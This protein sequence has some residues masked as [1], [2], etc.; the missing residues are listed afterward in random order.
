M[1][2]RP[3]ALFEVLKENG[4]RHDNALAGGFRDDALGGSLAGAS[5]L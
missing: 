1:T 4:S 2:D 5:Y 3:V